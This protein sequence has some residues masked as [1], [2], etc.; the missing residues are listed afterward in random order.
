MPRAGIA[1]YLTKP[2]SSRE[3]LRRHPDARWAPT[4]EGSAAPAAARDREAAPRRRRA[5]ASCW[6]RTTRSTSGWSSACSRRRGTPSPS[7]D[8]GREAPGRSG[9]DEPFDLVLM[10]VQMPDMD[11]F[12]ATAAIRAARDERGE[13]L[14]IIA[15]TAHAMKGDRERCLEA[16]HGRLRVEADSVPESLRRHR[17][18]GPAGAGIPRGARSAAGR[19]RHPRRPDARQR[20]PH[21]PPTGSRWPRPRRAAAASGWRRSPRRQRWRARAAIAG[22][23]K[24]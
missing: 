7:S 22:C 24:S 3:L 16:G 4:G 5:A 12:E 1:A 2:I 17:R 14:P 6:P 19:A 11:G 10:D 13:H 23:S 15:L 20:E 18:A 8:N 21:A 9:P